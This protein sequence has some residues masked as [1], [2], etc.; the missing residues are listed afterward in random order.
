MCIFVKKRNMT[1]PIQ[2]ISPLN[3]VQ[4]ML[5]RLFSR[6]VKTDDL[7]KIRDL[8]VS[9]YEEELQYELDRV[10]E[11]KDISRADFDNILSKQQRTV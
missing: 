5:L 1:A 9:Y 7:E 4:V 11:E 3:D 6:P 2:P 10:I 8:L